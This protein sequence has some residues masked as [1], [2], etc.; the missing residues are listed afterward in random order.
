MERPAELPLP[1]QF[2]REAPE[3]KAGGVG[4]AAVFLGGLDDGQREPEDDVVVEFPRIGGYKA[5]YYRLRFA[6]FAV[7]YY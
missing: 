4:A 2:L 7:F 3:I 5:E 6:V 1:H